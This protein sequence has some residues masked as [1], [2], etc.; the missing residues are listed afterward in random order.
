TRIRAAAPTGIDLDRIEAE[1]ECRAVETL[2]VGVA[3]GTGS[4]KT[5]LTKA[6]LDRCEGPPSVLYHDNYYRRR[7]ELSYEEREQVKYDD[8]DAFDDDIFVEQ[9]TALRT[10]RSH[11]RPLTNFH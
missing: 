7:D 5:T 2:V 9:L 10:A 6:L 1:E 11:D 3:G 8:L 4:G